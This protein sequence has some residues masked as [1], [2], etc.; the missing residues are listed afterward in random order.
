MSSGRHSPSPSPSGFSPGGPP[1]PSG[2]PGVL[3]TTTRGLNAS[4]HGVM[5]AFASAQAH[6]RGGGVAHARAQHFIRSAWRRVR[7]RIKFAPTREQCS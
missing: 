4:C 6:R 3:D 5:N 2:P 1:G 7:R